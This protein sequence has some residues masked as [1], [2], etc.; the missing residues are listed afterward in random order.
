MYQAGDV[1]LG[2]FATPEGTVIYHHSVVLLGN[3]EGALLVYTTSLKEPSAAEQVF[4]R[5]DMLMANWTRPCR[6]DA[7]Q[8]SLVPN[9]CLR[10]VGRISEATHSRI[11]A[12]YQAANRQRVL[13]VSHLTDAREVV[14]L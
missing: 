4:T 14:A 3:H 13:S 1:V 8:A 9:E 12:A 7:S 10:R 6:W 2:S 11:V 5:E